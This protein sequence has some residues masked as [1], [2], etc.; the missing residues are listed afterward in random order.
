MRELPENII[1]II[2][3]YCKSKKM[4]DSKKQKLFNIVNNRYNESLVS[5][6]DAVGLIAAQSIGEPGTQLTLRTK[7]YAGSLEV[8]VGSG[9]QRVIEIVDGRSS[10][11]NPS[12][13]IYL[14]KEFI[15]NEKQAK[16]FCN[17]LI[18]IKVKNIGYF[19]ENFV[20]KT[21]I[22][23]IDQDKIDYFNLDSEK[24]MLLIYDSIDNLYI[25]KR[26]S[27]NKTQINL[28]FDKDCSLYDIRKA[29]MK[30]NKIPLA[31]IKYI[32]KAVL[33]ERDG[34]FIII[35]KGSNLKE[36]LKLEEI[37][38]YRTITN[39]IFEIQKI[40]GIEAARECIVS[41]FRN[42]FKNNGINLNAR[43][44]YLLADIMTFSGSVQGIV[45]TG[46]T[47]HKKSPFARASFEETIKHILSAAFNN[48][49]ETLTGIVE[50]IIVGQPILAGTGTV[51]LT[52]DPKV[53]NKMIKANKKS[54]EEKQAEIK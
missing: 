43:H 34:E 42:T 13:E 54:K 47:G 11:K 51:R 23:K 30:W 31:G 39:D 48:E 1:E 17:S 37:D 21:V 33:Q 38:S 16:I 29:I 32:E 3:K 5:P 19:K 18:D 7:H 8:S 45:R 12:M 50:N 28:S 10:A 6:G 22:F 14:N 44:V 25:S 46:I 27:S 26:F 49:V 40:F 15:K 35:T 24:I 2:E 41:E 53:F 9:I 20:D 4:S 52:L 36:V